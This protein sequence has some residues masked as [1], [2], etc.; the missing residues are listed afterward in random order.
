MTGIDYRFANPDWKDFPWAP[1]SPLQVAS[2]VYAFV[3][4]LFGYYVFTHPRR[5]LIVCYEIFLALS[6]LFTLAIGIFAIIAGSTDYLNVQLGCQ[7]Y[8][9]GIMNV[10]TGIDN[11]IQRVDQALCSD[12]CPCAVRNTAP[13]TSNATIS[14]MFNT[15]NITDVSYGA[16]SFQNCSGSV[17]LNVY[18]DVVRTDPAFDPQRE[19]ND[20]KFFEYMSRVEEKFHCSGWCQTRYMN[21]NLNKE[22]MISKYLFSNI[23]R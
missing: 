9:D 1:L 14:P 18:N 7:A 21:T 5:A 11:Y 10:W 20:N 3:L 22:V 17:K 15:W 19:F 2:I 16:T 6:F 23:N 4:G 13:F 8:I 12:E